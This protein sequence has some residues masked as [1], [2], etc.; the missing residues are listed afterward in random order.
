MNNY[1]LCQLVSKSVTHSTNEFRNSLC[2]NQSVSETVSSLL[3]QSVHHSMNKCSPK[4]IS[5][6]RSNQLGIFSHQQRRELHR[7]DKTEAFRVQLS[8]TKRNQKQ[9]LNNTTVYKNGNSK[10]ITLKL[11]RYLKSYLWRGF[12]AIF[13]KQ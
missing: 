8:K 1:S 5:H 9:H 2:V 12:L 11:K 6:L 13:L 4:L 3:R 7:E 10:K